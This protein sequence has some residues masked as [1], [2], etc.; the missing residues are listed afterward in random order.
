MTRCPAGRG[1]RP[2][3]WRQSLR[4][5]VA[6]LRREVARADG[7][8]ASARDHQYRLGHDAVRD[9]QEAGLGVAAV[10]RLA[11]PR[12]RHSTLR[13]IPLIEPEV[14]RTLRLLRRKNHPLSPTAKVL[15]DQIKKEPGRL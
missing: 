9:I 15:Y 1:W 14:S 11:L 8:A 4:G 2:R 10:P 7:R 5:A 12:K 6:A 3:L 13:G